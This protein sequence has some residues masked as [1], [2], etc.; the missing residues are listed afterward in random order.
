MTS[1][2]ARIRNLR[3]IAMGLKGSPQSVLDI[4]RW[5]RDRDRTTVEARQPWWCYPA[6]AEVARQLR[7]GSQVFEFGAGGSTLWLH[8]RGVSITSVENDRG[9]YDQ[10]TALLPP[11]VTVLL[12]EPATEGVM[13][14]AVAPGLFFDDYVAAISAVPEASLDLVIVDGRARVECGRA[15]MSK[16]KPGG[17]LL[18]DDSNRPR[19]QLLHEA[20]SDWPKETFCGLKPGGGAFF[21]TTMWRRPASPVPTN[22]TS[23]QL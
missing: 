16:V 4:P 7:P 18:L 23:S 17:H 15:A 9:W 1:A 14:S 11:D 10:L 8:D 13:G 20:L 22:R 21:Y 2:R 3:N 19:Y 6:A 12:R 5:R